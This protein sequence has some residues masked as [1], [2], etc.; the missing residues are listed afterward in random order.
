MEREKFSLVEIF[1]CL[2][3]PPDVFSTLDPRLKWLGE[4]EEGACW[5]SW[6]GTLTP[7][8]PR[9]HH[10]S[11]PAHMDLDE[12][13][14]SKSSLGVCPDCGDDD[15]LIM[16][17]SRECGLSVISCCICDFSFRASVDEES[18]E[19]MFFKRHRI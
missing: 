5:C 8:I 19:E 13:Q 9:N 17:S 7:S 4:C 1:G 11:C 15:S 10:N 16:H 12:F 6:C 14:V 18:L 3:V 2:P